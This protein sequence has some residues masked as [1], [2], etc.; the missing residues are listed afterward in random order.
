MLKRPRLDYHPAGHPV[1][2]K[3][4]ID[5]YAAE[6]IGDY[7]PFYVR[8]PGQLPIIELLELLHSE[9]GV[10]CNVAEL[11]E[12]GSRKVLGRIFPRKS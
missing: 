1:L 4:P 7:F 12:E 5:T 2:S 10:S 3:A 9:D 8:N 6:F 11:G